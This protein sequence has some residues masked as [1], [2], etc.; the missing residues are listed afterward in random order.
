M[1]AQITVPCEMLSHRIAR[2]AIHGIREDGSVGILFNE[3]R[4]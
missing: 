1:R 3:S 2:K 4:N